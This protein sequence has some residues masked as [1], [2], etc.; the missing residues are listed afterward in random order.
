MKLVSLFQHLDIVL[1]EISNSTSSEME[2]VDYAWLDLFV[3]EGTYLYLGDDSGE[4]GAR[5]EDIDY[6]FSLELQE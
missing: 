1:T 5:P 6:S 3:I 4:D 2:D